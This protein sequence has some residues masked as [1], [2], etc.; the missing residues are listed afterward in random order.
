MFG[1]VEKLLSRWTQLQINYSYYIYTEWFMEQKP[2]R[3]L[4]AKTSF[5]TIIGFLSVTS[6][7]QNLLNNLWVLL[8]LG[9]LPWR[10]MNF[11][12]WSL[13]DRIVEKCLFLKFLCQPF[14]R[15]V[16]T[17][18]EF[19]WPPLTSYDL[20]WPHLT[21]SDIIWP[22]LRLSLTSDD[23]F[24]PLITLSNYMSVPDYLWLVKSWC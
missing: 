16:L 18:F 1:T 17:S 3:I 22:Y 21:N 11:I 19:L 2:P 9:P 7:I 4:Q 8:E 20:L 10:Q 23:L 13:P 12:Q 5:H 6:L 15:L 24:Q 14:D